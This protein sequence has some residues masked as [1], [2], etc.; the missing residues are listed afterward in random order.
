[1]K[2]VRKLIIEKIYNSQNISIFINIVI[3]KIKNYVNIKDFI[4]TY[5]FISVSV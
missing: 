4:F 2:F 1:M 5:D 3:N